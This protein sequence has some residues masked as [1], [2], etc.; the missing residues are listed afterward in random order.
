MGE[1]NDLVFIFIFPH[2]RSEATR[3]L[4]SVIEI[5]RQTGTRTPK[6]LQSLP[7]DA[8]IFA[9]GASSALWRRHNST[10]CKHDTNQGGQREG[11][12]RVDPDASRE[13]LGK[14]TQRTGHLASAGKQVFSEAVSSAFTGAKSLTLATVSAVTGRSIPTVNSPEGW[15]FKQTMVAATTYMY[16]ATAFGIATAPMEGID[17]RKY[18][19][20]L[21]IPDRFEIPVVI[22]TGYPGASD[23]KV[24]PRLPVENLV[25]FNTY[26]GE[27]E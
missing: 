10:T 27:G 9:P 1:Y 2:A 5:E 3:R 6:Y 13:W 8:S 19:S 16:A 17:T 4:D 14:M 7:F 25:S 12:S 24:T 26:K 11:S 15:S 23:R 20:V 18:K 21:N 22:A